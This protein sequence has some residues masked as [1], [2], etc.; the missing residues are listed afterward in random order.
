M[1]AQC[2]VLVGG[3][4]AL[5]QIQRC[6][7]GQTKTC[8]LLVLHFLSCPSLLLQP[9]PQRAC[10]YWVESSWSTPG[11]S[12]DRCRPFLSW[13]W[14][15][16]ALNTHKSEAGGGIHQV[17]QFVLLKYNLYFCICCILTLGFLK[18]STLLLVFLGDCAGRGKRVQ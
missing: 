6:H 2:C 17:S 7:L 11:A 16:T 1:F 9:S 13:V 12:L 10:G 14:G 4:T 18:L 3:A 5:G 15:H 8:P